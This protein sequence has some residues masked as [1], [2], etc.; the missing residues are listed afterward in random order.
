MVGAAGADER[1]EGAERVLHVPCTLCGA[2][3]RVP[4]ARAGDR[5]R[6]GHC[7]VPF[8]EGKPFA[9]SGARLPRF[10][11]RSD[12]PFVLDAWATWCGPCRVF[13]PAYAEVAAARRGRVLCGK[14]D[15]D[16]EQAAAARLGI[17]SVPTTILFVAGRE[18]DRLG[19]AQ[20]AAS[21]HA[22]LDRHLEPET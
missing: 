4:A 11:E 14:L 17:A 16:A 6:C 7:G 3:N 15:I 19:G 8:L 22:W 9:V 12:L 5:P 21:L 1:T 2:V 20:S 10:V 18:V 13:E